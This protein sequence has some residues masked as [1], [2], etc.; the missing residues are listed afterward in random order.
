[1]YRGLIYLRGI[2]A[3]IAPTKTKK[4]G[5]IMTQKEFNKM[6][7]DSK[8]IINDLTREIVLLRGMNNN[9]L[10]LIRDKEIELKRTVENM[11]RNYLLYYGI[12]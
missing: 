1:M 12:E 3:R 8:N 5:C 4:K 9:N 6:M 7:S 2:I 11:G 10:E